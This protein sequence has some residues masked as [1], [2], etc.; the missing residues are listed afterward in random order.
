MCMR[1]TIS[2]CAA[3]YYG[4][5]ETV[6][7][8][9]DAGAD[10]HAQDDYALRCG[11]R[12]GHTGTVKLLLDR[13]AAVHAWGDYALRGARVRGHSETVKVLETA[14]KAAAVVSGMQK[15]FKEIGVELTQEQAVKVSGLVAGLAAKGGVASPARPSGGAVE[16]QA[17]AP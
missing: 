4:H 17:P 16:P 7:V 8:L 14:M 9:L 1:G 10:V 6:K 15:L 3:S 12:D 13:G 11:S 2:R 5:T